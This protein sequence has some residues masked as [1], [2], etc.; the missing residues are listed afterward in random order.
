MDTRIL[1][2]II[3]LIAGGAFS[4]LGAIFD[5]DFFFNSYKARRMVNFIGKTGAR[6][7]YVVVGVFLIVF[8]ICVA[9]GIIQY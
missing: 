3:L 5:W 9:L 2:L 1:I 6:I 4:L 8:G 7:F